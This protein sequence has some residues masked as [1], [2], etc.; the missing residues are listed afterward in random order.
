M[1]VYGQ[2][3]GFADEVRW[4][5]LPGP[6]LRI[7]MLVLRKVLTRK[8]WNFLDSAYTSADWTL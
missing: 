1:N 7:R 5:F 2:K 6:A 8:I 4:G 3:S